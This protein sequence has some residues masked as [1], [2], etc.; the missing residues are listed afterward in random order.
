M[1]SMRETARRFPQSTARDLEPVQFARRS[2]FRNWRGSITSQTYQLWHDSKRL[3]IVT[4]IDWHERQVLLKAHFPLA[5]RSDHA[6]FETMYGAV[7]RPTHRNSALGMP[8]ASK[9]VVIASGI[10]GTRLW[11]GDAKRFEVRI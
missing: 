3:D 4:E 5:V 6:V 11:S 1:R 9:A 10:F 2:W 7:T 8:L